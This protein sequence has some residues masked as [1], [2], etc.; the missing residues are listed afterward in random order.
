[1][2]GARKIIEQII[3]EMLFESHSIEWLLCIH[4]VDLKIEIDEF[5]E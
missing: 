5:Y 4:I 2:G 3:V 1:M